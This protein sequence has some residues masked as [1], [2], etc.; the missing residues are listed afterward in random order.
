MYILYTHRKEDKLHWCTES[1][2]SVIQE[3]AVKKVKHKNPLIELQLSG[4]FSEHV[5]CYQLHDTP[6]LTMVS[7]SVI[8]KF[9]FQEQKLYTV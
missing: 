4:Y 8:A 9:V 5:P 2:L 6:K 1:V 7:L 3:G